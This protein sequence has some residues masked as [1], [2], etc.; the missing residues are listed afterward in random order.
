MKKLLLSL[1]FGMTF[2]GYSFADN[3][4]GT[5]LQDSTGN[6]ITT[7]NPLQVHC[8]S[9]CGGGTGSPGGSNTQLQY[10]NSGAFGGI[11][12]ATT[13]GT[14]L[15]LTAPSLGTPSSL[16]LTNATG[17]PLSTGVTGNLSVNNLNSG[18]SASSSTYWRG[19]GAWATPSGSGT[20][21][22]G[23]ANQAA[24]YASSTA[25]VSG[26]SDL[27]FNGANV[28]IGSANPSQILDVAGTVRSNAFTT[29]GA[30]TQT[31]T[32]ANA[33]TGISTFSNATN[34]AL[35]T[36]G[37]VGIGSTI[38]T[39]L[40]DIQGASPELGFN[41]TSSSNKAWHIGATGNNLQIIENSVGTSMMTLQAGGNV[42]IGSTNP[43]GVLTV[44][45]SIN[46]Y[47][48]IR[49]TG[50]GGSY[51]NELVTDTASGIGAN[52]LAFMPNSASSGSAKVVFKT[53]G[54]VGI[55]S[56]NP[57]QTLDVTGTVRMSQQIFVSGIATDAT[58]TDATVC[59]DT[60]THQFYSG[61][62]TL[63]ICLGTS[64]MLAKQNIVPI[65]EGISQ[66]MA[67]KPVSFNYRPGWGYDVKKPYYG[68][69]AEQVAPVLPRLVGHDAQGV[70]KN[71]DYVGM[72]PV[73]VKA[74][75]QE[76]VQQRR[77]NYMNAFI[78]IMFTVMVLMIR[79]K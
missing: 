70:I 47:F 23:T 5:I 40:L 31:G 25:A 21:N 19:D 43:D 42:G 46:P 4:N 30:Y 71:A 76:E 64:T 8:V 78:V 62:G 74:I 26:T 79:F 9:G 32:S 63:G 57:G 15:T 6:A 28:G 24:Y 20:V 1:I 59:E 58:K 45:S 53:D 33:F 48:L 61:S 68:F 29:T 14:S 16:V 39:Q 36:G 22:S 69:I 73:M 3:G 75:Q 11:T 41:N 27:I 18:T 55:G 50:A 52:Y 51:W 66:I 17:L 67:L 44:S 49:S 72:I 37:N 56:T 7:S 35:F 10:N 65:S 13:N 60:T 12:G 34:S 77:Q 54:N 2:I 38:P